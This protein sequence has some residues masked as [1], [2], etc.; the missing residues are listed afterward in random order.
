MSMSQAE[1]LPLYRKLRSAMKPLHHEMIR[2]LSRQTFVETGK[3]LGIYRR[4]TLVFDTED[5][6]CVLMDQCLY[7]YRPH[8]TTAVE[9]YLRDHPPP[10]DTNEHILLNAMVKARYSLF[11]VESVERGLGLRTA[12][13]LY[14][15]GDFILDQNLS[16]TVFPGFVIA[17]R[18][19]PLGGECFMTTGA[20]LPVE[21]D[22]LAQLLKSLNLD[23]SKGAQAKRREDPRARFELSTRIV[24][25]LLR[26]GAAKSVAYADV[27]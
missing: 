24:R 21:P 8:G 9:R 19:I 11:Q 7:D 26:T 14:G 4:G 27:R 3:A 20:G 1:I 18:I 2:G 13:L 16:Q 23:I 15:H 5:E 25:F 6:S 10:P 22:C 17:T 12:D